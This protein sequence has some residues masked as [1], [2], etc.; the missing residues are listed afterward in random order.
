MWSFMSI[1]SV[2]CITVFPTHSQPL[3]H[4]GNWCSIIF[5]QILFRNVNIIFIRLIRPHY[6]KRMAI[7]ICRISTCQVVN[8]ADLKTF[9]G[10]SNQWTNHH[11]TYQ[12]KSYPGLLF[13]SNFI[14]NKWQSLFHYLRKNLAK[15]RVLILYSTNPMKHRFFPQR[16][17]SSW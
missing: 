1:R 2:I 15:K 11:K 3:L 6:I 13:P 12:V 14:T 10:H 8:R 17:F 4:H 5:N 7:D 16:F 9:N